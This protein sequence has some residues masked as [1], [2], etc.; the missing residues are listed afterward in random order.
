MPT[1]VKPIDK[2]YRTTPEARAAVYE[3]REELLEAGIEIMR[4]YLDETEKW[5]KN[6]QI[7][8]PQPLPMDP[9]HPM[10]DESWRHAVKS[11]T[12]E[13][14]KTV[15]QMFWVNLFKIEGSAEQVYQAELHHRVKMGIEQPDLLK[16]FGDP[17]APLN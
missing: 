2:Y 6:Y 5:L 9:K 10:C 15:S 8:N 12:V 4:R 17:N 13:M 1:D 14:P 16:M 7:M 3:A 11:L